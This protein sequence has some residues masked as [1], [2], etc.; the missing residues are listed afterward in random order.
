MPHAAR[1]R[2]R[3]RRRS[4]DVEERVRPQ[5]DDQDQEQEQEDTRSSQD[6]GGGAI[7]ER[8]DVMSEAA[9]SVR[10]PVAKKLATQAAK[11][12]VERGPDLLEGTILPKLTDLGGNLGEK[13]GGLGGGDDE[14]G[15]GGNAG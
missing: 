11:M 9:V 6:S 10:S 12:A 7:T 1:E 14:E 2:S 3:T 8:K 5:D 4:R 13:F 15:G